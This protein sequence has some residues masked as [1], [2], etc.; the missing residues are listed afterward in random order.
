MQ[1]LF[2]FAK[3]TKRIWKGWTASIKEREIKKS[4]IA[5]LGIAFALTCGALTGCGASND[6]VDEPVSIE[7]AV[8]NYVAEDH[9]SDIQDVTVLEVA[10]DE[11]YGGGKSVF[12]RYSADGCTFYKNIAISEL[13]NVEF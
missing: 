11:Y 8:A 3:N 5:I 9:H 6:V 10:D 4:F 1:R 12:V 13:G 7:T 2:L